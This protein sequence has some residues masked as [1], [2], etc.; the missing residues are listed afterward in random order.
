[1][2]CLSLGLFL[3]F[4]FCLPCDGSGHRSFIGFLCFV[5][6]E[7]NLNRMHNAQSYERGERN[8]EGQRMHFF[9]S[10]KENKIQAWQVAL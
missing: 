4:L 5:F 1:V 3:A 2:G 8:R 10:M 7:L 9:N 6:H